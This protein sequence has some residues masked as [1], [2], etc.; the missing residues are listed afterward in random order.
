MGALGRFFVAVGLSDDHRH[1]LAA[2]LTDTVGDLPGKPISPANW[3][4]TVRFLGDLTDTQYDRFVHELD[5]VDKPAPFRMTFAGLGAFPKATAASVLWLGINQ[6]VG[7][8]QELAAAS[9]TAAHLAGLPPED[10]PFVPHLTLARVQPPR[11]VW[12]WLAQVPEP[13]VRVDVERLEVFR[14]HLGDA[15]AEYEMLDEIEL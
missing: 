13:P 3:H 4:L 10:R 8:M 14:S 1:A 6:G 11:D 5:G 15:G 12:P 9:E 7:G 2:F